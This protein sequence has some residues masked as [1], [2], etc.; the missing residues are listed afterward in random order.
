[1]LRKIFIYIGLTA[2]ILIFAGYFYFAST[3]VKQGE[4]NE[5]C[6]QVKVLVLDSHEN[7]FVSE[8]DV[9]NI[10]INS[11]LK[12]IGRN[13]NDLNVLELEKLLNKKSAI[14]NSEVS[15]SRSGL[16][17]VSITQR[18]PMLRIQTKNGGFY[19]DDTGYVFPL[20]TSFTSYV[21]I[22]SGNIPIKLREGQ[23]GR[24]DSKE[25]DWINSVLKF[26][27]YIDK[28]E[29]WNSQIQQIYIEKNGDVTLFTRVGDHTINFGPIDNI[30]Y[31]F[32]KLSTFYQNIVPI[33]G[34]NKY[35]TVNLK[36]S[37]QIVCTLRD[38]EN[39]RR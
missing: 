39:K 29:F 3:L 18:R 7:R 1:M 9:K 25:N 20:V 37:N 6:N 38:I 17:R 23:R 22:I 15:V 4:A 27:E 33:Y 30:G 16:L 10:L 32:K 31:K 13:I 24:V 21:P 19:I 34:W 12:P 36:Y 35:S 28:Y 26:G 5:I 8:K 2:I 14:K 11:S